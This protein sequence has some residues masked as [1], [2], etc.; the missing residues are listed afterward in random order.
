MYKRELNIIDD[1]YEYHIWFLYRNVNSSSNVYRSC[2]HYYGKINDAVNYLQKMFKRF[3]LD[4]SN[5][6][7]IDYIKYNDFEFDCGNEH[8]ILNAEF[9]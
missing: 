8:Y 2:Y 6:K 7:I 9:N 4:I 5:E 3:N 1:N